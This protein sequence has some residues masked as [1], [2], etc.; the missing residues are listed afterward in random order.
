MLIGDGRKGLPSQ[1]PNRDVGK[2]FRPLIWRVRQERI[3]LPSAATLRRQGIDFNYAL[4]RPL[5]VLA[6]L[7]STCVPAARGLLRVPSVPR[8]ISSYIVLLSSLIVP[9][10]L[11]GPSVGERV[12]CERA[13][14]F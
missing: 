10:P 5:L 8:S 14:C 3:S 6:D 9:D 13:N 4:G 7:I 2:E 11:F 12:A 1:L